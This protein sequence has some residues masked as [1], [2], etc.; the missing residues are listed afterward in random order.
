[1]VR[2]VCGRDLH[3]LESIC[4]MCTSANHVLKPEPGHLGITGYPVG[5]LVEGPP[6]STA[7]RLVD[8][9]PASDGRSYSS[10]DSTARSRQISPGRLFEAARVRGGS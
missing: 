8:S 4:P 5:T 2:A 1:M 10:T 7:G 3:P 6:D 9:R